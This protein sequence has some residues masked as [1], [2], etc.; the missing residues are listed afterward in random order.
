MMLMVKAIE[1]EVD[2]LLLWLTLGLKT[3]LEESG[4]ILM[5]NVANLELPAAILGCGVGKLPSSHLGL[6]SS[7]LESK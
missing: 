6:L 5:G 2:S 4:L 1:Y 3:D 7:A